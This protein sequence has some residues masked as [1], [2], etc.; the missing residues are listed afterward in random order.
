MIYPIW[1]EQKNS[2]THTHTPKLTLTT[3][4][5]RWK[6]EAKKIDRER[7]C[8]I[9]FAIAATANFNSYHFDSYLW[10][11]NETPKHSYQPQIQM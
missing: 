7:E 9:F 2:H 6:K 8:N 4:E 5:K 11:H 1:G 10:M 3:E